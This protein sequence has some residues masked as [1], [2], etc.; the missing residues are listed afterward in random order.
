LDTGAEGKGVAAGEH[1]QLRL[2]DQQTGVIP[3]ELT[4]VGRQVRERS[5]EASVRADTWSF[6]DHALVETLVALLLAR[7]Q[8]LQGERGAQGSLS[9]PQ[10]TLCVVL[11]R[12]LAD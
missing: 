5:V 4:A 8:F 2:A 1:S 3:M 9:Q 10:Q 12:S 11:R 7:S 6:A